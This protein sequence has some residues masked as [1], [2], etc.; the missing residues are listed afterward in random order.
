MPFFRVD[1]NAQTGED[2]TLRLSEWQVSRRSRR[3]RYAYLV[4]GSDSAY[5]GTE[6]VIRCLWE[7][8]PPEDAAKINRMCASIRSGYEV[9]VRIYGTDDDETMGF[10]FRD[11]AG[12]LLPEAQRGFPVDLEEDEIEESTGV[13]VDQFPIEFTLV[14]KVNTG[15]GKTDV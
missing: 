3:A 2:F 4:G 15:A 13:I 12:N 5:F 6:L 14:T 7:Y 8:L 10:P 9:R 1:Y 11:G